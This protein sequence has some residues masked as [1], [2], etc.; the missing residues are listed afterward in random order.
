MPKDKKENPLIFDIPGKG[1]ITIYSNCDEWYLSPKDD[2]ANKERTYLNNEWFHEKLKDNLKGI[3][4]FACLFDHECDFRLGKILIAL[5]H[6]ANIDFVG[7][8][9]MDMDIYA[10]EVFAQDATKCDELHW[11]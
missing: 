11:W 7:N 6:M 5:Y 4:E 2:Y 8:G 1:K 10:L 9:N 3:C